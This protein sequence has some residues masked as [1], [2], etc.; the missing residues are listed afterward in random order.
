MKSSKS[1]HSASKHSATA[2]AVAPEPKRVWWPYAVTIVFALFAVFEV[3]GPALNGPFL[4]DDTYLPYQ[5]PEFVA[6]PLRAWISGV[7]PM[8]MFSFWLNYKEYG[9]QDTS[10]YHDVNLILHFLSGILA[11]LAVRKLLTWTDGDKTKTEILSAF[12]GG[13]FLFHP[14][15]TE[16]VSYVA[17][18]SE[19]L[20]V[21]FVLAAYVVFLYRKTAAISWLA[22]LV[23]VLLYGAAVLTKEHTVALAGLFLLTDYFLNPGFS[24]DGIRRNWR[25]YVPVAI[26]GLLG[27]RFV[28]RVLTEASTGGVGGAGTAGFGMKGLTWYQYFFTQCRAIWDYVRMFLFPFGQ[29]LDYDYPISKTILDHGTVLGLIGLVALI[30]LAWYYRRRFPLISYGIFTLL[31]LLAPT[32]SFVPIRD[33]LV[34]RRLYLPFVGLLFITVGLLRLWKASRTTLVFTLSLVLL[35]EGAFAYQRNQLWSNA[36]AIW[37]DSVSKSPNKYRPRFQLAFAYYQAGR[38][39]EAVDE[40]GKTAQLEKP[41]SSLLVDWA[42]AYDCAGN[43]ATAVAKLNE[44]AKLEATAHV[45]SQIGMEYAKQQK[46]SE[47]LDALNR[48]AAL[49]PNFE[50]TYQYRGDV[51]KLRGDL[52]KAAEEYRRVLAI[53]PQSELARRSLQSIGQ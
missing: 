36:V 40:F 45:Y 29:N 35:V 4:L 20:S 27:L 18:R 50:M 48:A 51:F 33:P 25:M 47:A 2:I 31:L 1:K 28:W 17:S 30:A 43:P 46:Y 34:E 11:Y 32:S 12:A 24:L 49:D 10:S 26:G 42:L 7:R 23:V 38:C 21:F 37:H 53:N 6:A 5:R 44:A 41:D 52:P 8:L 19:T 14:I 15:Q 16:S 13:L 9:N 22:A 3:Y 39:G